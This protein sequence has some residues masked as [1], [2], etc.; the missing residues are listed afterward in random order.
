M[1][2]K[3]IGIV[4][5]ANPI[6]RALAD[7]LIAFAA[8]NVPQ[9]EL[10]FHPQCFL[11]DGHFAGP[12]EVRA[13]ALIEVANDPAIDAVW[14]AR[15][16]YGSNRI[17]ASIVPQLNASARAKTWLGYS[18][19]GFLLAALYKAGFP[20]LAH[21]PVARDIMREGGEAAALRALRFLTARDPATLEP[22]V[23]TDAAPK[24]AFNL[25]ILSHLIG[26]SFMPDLAG[27][28]VM[29]EEVSEELYRIDRSFFHITSALANIKGLRL[30]RISDIRPNDPDFGMT[31][32]DIAQHW[33]TRAGLPYLGEADI[34]HDA[35]NKIVPFGV[36]L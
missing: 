22:Q 20:H 2:T 33:C 7:R 6:D 31:A 32:E 3:K 17:A 9:A 12:D 25:C 26:T 4:A 1:Q 36:W 27:H 21:G 35:Q 10:Y 13:S 23:T 28:V 18:D 19:A 29:V 24:A 15:G 14:W 5:P 16:G 30:G 34:G 11:S 8:Q